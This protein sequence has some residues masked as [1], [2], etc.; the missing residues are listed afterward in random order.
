MLGLQGVYT[1]LVTPFV[2]GRIDEPAVV[3]L[4]ERQLAAGVAGVVVASG[5]AGEGMSLRDAETAALLDLAVRTVRGRASVLSGASSNSTTGAAELAR[6]A[7]GLGV[8]AV[9]VTAPW[10]IRP[11]QAGLLQHF[12]HVA[13]AVSCPIIVGD[14]PARTGVNIHIS[15]LAGISRLAN[16]VGV[17]DA[18]GDMAR[19]TAIRRA[20][21][22]WALLSAHDLS[23]LGCLAHGASGLVSLTS[24][25]APEAVVAACLV[26]LAGRRAEAERLQ[27]RLFDLQS[28]VTQDPSPAAVKW[29]LSRLGRCGPEV[30]LPM[31]P[32]PDQDEVLEGLLKVL[33]VT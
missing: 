2:D 1:E 4:I 26:G 11:S 14:A 29:A 9:I 27:G 13:T 28:A 16:V 22:N 7:E 12:E 30:R 8:D 17:T 10:Y 19:A 18:S 32:W 3:V 5:A 21:P 23:A 33:D 20:C 24:N 6:Q 15:T 25:L 31:T